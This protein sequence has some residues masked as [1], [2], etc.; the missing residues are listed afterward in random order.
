MNARPN[1]PKTHDAARELLNSAGLN[2]TAARLA[3]LEELDGDLT[4]ATAEELYHR[5]QRRLDR[6][7]RPGRRAHNRAAISRA[8]IYNCLEALVKIGY[9]NIL[10]GTG[11]RRFDPNCKQHFHAICTVCGAILDVEPEQILQN[12]ARQAP[13]VLA[14]GFR[15]QTVDLRLGGQC[16]KCVRN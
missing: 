16:G 3:I 14:S 7:S 2:V 13:A 12:G 1:S 10:E 8:T 6:G 4:H 15:V 5:I 11:V 9:L